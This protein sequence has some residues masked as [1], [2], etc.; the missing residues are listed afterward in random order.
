MIVE[1]NQTNVFIYFVTSIISTLVLRQYIYGPIIF[2]LCIMIL[3][4]N[5]FYKH[6][7][8]ELSKDYKFITT[9]PSYVLIM[10]L[11][12]I[13]S[14]VTYKNET[15]SV[16]YKLFTISFLVLSIVISVIKNMTK[17]EI[18]N[19][20]MGN[21]VPTLLFCTFLIQ[22]SY[23]RENKDYLHVKYTELID[24]MSQ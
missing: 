12:S 3:G 17:N 4:R 16:E 19:S 8:K 1:F 7:V 10:V 20:T 24:Y 9:L 18:I 15:I 5:M 23:Y 14:Y 22:V 11:L 13:G 6:V 2:L 21:L